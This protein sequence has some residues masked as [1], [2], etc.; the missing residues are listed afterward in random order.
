MKSV[1]DL[2]KSDE[3]RKSMLDLQK[4]LKEVFKFNKN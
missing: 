3:M 1:C 2:S 4:D